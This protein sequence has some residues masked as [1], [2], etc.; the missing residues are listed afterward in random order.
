MSVGALVSA[1]CAST[2]GYLPE[3]AQGGNN[4]VLVG[5]PSGLSDD[6]SQSICAQFQN[7]ERCKHI[8][9][10]KGV[11]LWVS[12]SAVPFAPIKT[13][14]VLVPKGINFPRASLLKVRVKGNAPAYF[15]EVAAIG[16]DK[17]DCYR[18]GLYGRG[19]GGP[20][21]VVCPK[22]NYDYRTVPGLN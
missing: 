20:G 13:V 15:E 3:I 7:D 9:D 22:H 14:P 16:L 19:S 10:Y 11:S 12:E 21:G 5:Q 8:G 18:L 1:G 6:I 4:I 2:S 17:P